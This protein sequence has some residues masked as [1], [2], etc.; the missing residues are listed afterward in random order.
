MPTLPPSAAQAG[1]AAVV[2]GLVFDIA[3]SQRGGAEGVAS[4]LN[5]V[6]RAGDDG[7]CQVGVVAD[8]DLKTVVAGTDIPLSI[9]QAEGG[10]SE[11][12]IFCFYLCGGVGGGLIAG[13]R[14][15]ASD[16]RADDIFVGFFFD[17]CP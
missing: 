6:V 13:G 4:G 14:G 16:N 12:I 9:S 15:D 5:G 7:T 8:P 2:A 3:V 1:A 17:K 11:G 10:D